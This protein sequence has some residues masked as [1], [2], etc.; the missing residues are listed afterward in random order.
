MTRRLLAV[1]AAALMLLNP[2]AVFAAA[3]EST[4]SEP[5]TPAVQSADT[6]ES[7]VLSLPD[8]Q[9]DAE[10]VE[11]PSPDAQSDA[12]SPDPG[13]IPDFS[14]EN[15][16]EFLDMLKNLDKETL[17][18]DLEMIK[19]L[20]ESEDFRHFMSYQE[21]Q[22]LVT[23]TLKKIQDFIQEDRELVGKICNTLGI[24]ETSVRLVVK[25]SDFLDSHRDDLKKAL[26][27]K[28]GTETMET[29]KP[30]LEDRDVYDL[31]L[32]ILDDLYAAG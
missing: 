31:L 22:D 29:L 1:L 15:S 26:D 30:L 32:M 3:A 25:F 19:A 23:M 2:A 5:D 20:L 14:D 9:S 10:S 17:M 21:I 13:D 16:Q 8:V 18:A 4:I 12:E 6:P 11:T 7:A 27:S 24:D 28:A